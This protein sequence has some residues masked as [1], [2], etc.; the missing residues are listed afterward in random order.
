[1]CRLQRR[2]IDPRCARR[3]G[4][5]LFETGDRILRAERRNREGGDAGKRIRKKVQEEYM[6]QKKPASSAP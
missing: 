3:C 2:F 4:I 1:M 6:G 5:F